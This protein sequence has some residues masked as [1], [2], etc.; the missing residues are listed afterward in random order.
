MDND[1]CQND[2]LGQ[3]DDITKRP[4]LLNLLVVITLKHMIR[5]VQLYCKLASSSY[6]QPAFLVVIQ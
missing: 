5:V 6:S 2:N 1:G 4:P 3:D